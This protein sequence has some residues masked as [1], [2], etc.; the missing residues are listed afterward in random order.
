L[1]IPAA[2]KARAKEFR[3]ADLVPFDWADPLDLEAQLSEEERMIRDAA[4]GFAQDVL[5]PR[6]IEAYRDESTRPSCSR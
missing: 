2:A 3:M 6:V 1:A 5:Q 4:R